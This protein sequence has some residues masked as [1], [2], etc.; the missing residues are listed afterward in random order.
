VSRDHAVGVLTFMRDQPGFYTDGHARLGRAIGSQIAIAVDRARS[1]E[2]EAQRSRELSTL[3]DV[4]RNVSSSTEFGPLLELILDQL[5][6]VVDFDRAVVWVHEEDA[7]VV[8][9]ARDFGETEGYVT[10]TR[11]GDSIDASDGALPSWFNGDEPVII[12][13]VRA[14]TPE[15]REYRANLRED[16]ASDPPHGSYMGIPLFVQ[17]HVVGMLALAR[18]EPGYYTREHARLGSAI[19][20]QIAVA[21]DNARLF[22]ETRRS[23]RETEVL[24]R[25]DAE[26][27]RSLELDTVLQ[28]LVDVAVDVLG[29]D[30]SIVVLHEGEIDI[31]RATRNYD[32]ANIAQFNRQLAARPH[33]EPPPGE[34]TPR[35]YIDVA[36]APDFIAEALVAESIA[37]HISVPVRDTQ[38]MLGVFGVSF[39]QR[40]LFTDDERRLY[41]AL[42]DRAAV[43]IQNAELYEKAQHAASLEERQRLA[44]ELHDSV[45]QALY[46]IALGTRTARLRI[47]ENPAT[48]AEPIEYVATL[49][50]AGL[51]EMRALIFELRP[52]SLE[53]EGLVAAIEKQVASTRARHQLSIEAHLIDE[54]DCRIDV[55]EALYRITQEA[56]QN[57]VKH[58]AATSA[59][60]ELVR[61]D[62][63]LRLSVSDDGRG[64]DP[65]QQF[66]GHIGLHSMPERAAKLGGTVVVE[67]TPGQ[68]TRVV[69]E[70]PL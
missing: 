13:D 33:E 17:D 29:V 2:R 28:A 60:V 19:G 55:K 51:A 23:A 1:F 68:G 40:H 8:R 58:A 63:L 32:P 9:A 62:G 7:L 20:S 15:A 36:E 54:P 4:A 43:A 37:S 67:S 14:E 12:D 52:E 47:D 61:S 57:V 48:A 26:L 49:A 31:V 65:T 38:R 53:T 22:E 45:S 69:A 50:E 39:L 24:V 46:G 16:R 5:S 3:L 6:S 18:D 41:N 25:A 70:I 64:F 42:A 27:F 59:T 21:I 10:S 56:L 35:E 11:I 66:P 34:E 30:K 44:R